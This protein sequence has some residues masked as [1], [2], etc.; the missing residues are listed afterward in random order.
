MLNSIN[1]EREDKISLREMDEII[2]N[3]F[4]L[5]VDAENLFLKDQIEES[6]AGLQYEGE[7]EFLQG[8]KLLNV[9]D[10]KINAMECTDLIH[11]VKVSH[12]NVIN[13]IPLT[14]LCIY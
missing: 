9:F 5:F 11:D 1:L 12:E 7:K 4:M 14:F 8:G 3:I 13:H 10:D 2:A 6:Y